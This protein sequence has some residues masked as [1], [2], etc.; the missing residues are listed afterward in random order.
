MRTEERSFR[1]SLIS[2]IS[3]NY[4]GY[5]GIGPEDER[6]P[7]PDLRN[8]ENRG[9]QQQV[10]VGILIYVTVNNR[11]VLLRNQTMPFPQQL[12]ASQLP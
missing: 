9:G 11:R 6:H 10:E 8:V 3:A 2:P 7:G 12:L 4:A 5:R 1:E